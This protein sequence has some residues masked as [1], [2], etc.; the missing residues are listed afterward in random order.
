ML[1]KILG[2]SA[3]AAAALL[4]GSM[5]GLAHEGHDDMCD[6]VVASD[7][8]NVGTSSGKPLLLGHSA[9][10]PV[11]EVAVIE[12]AAGPLP[13]DGMVFFALD[14]ADLDSEDQSMLDDII[15]EVKERNPAS[16]TVMGHTD[17]SGNA[18]HNMAL[19]ER[20]AE[21]IATA[22]TAAGIPVSAINTMGYGQTE[23]A[24]ETED[25][26]AMRQNRR[27]VVDVQ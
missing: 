11:E 23:L 13:H 21:T 8:E 20:R 5:P 9:P 26:V 16:V 15:K 2:C 10:C 12:P 22:M 18:D 19:S 24:V 17:T 4:V 7:G 3:I 6:V 27:T 14:S 1:S 25:G